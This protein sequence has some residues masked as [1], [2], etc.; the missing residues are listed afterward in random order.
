MNKQINREDQEITIDLL[1]V[2]KTLWR[3]KWVIILTTLF[4][5]LIVGAFTKFFITPKYTSTTSMYVFVQAKDSN[6]NNV[7]VSQGLAKDSV[8]LGTSETVLGTAIK[9]V[10]ES[11]I[12]AIT[13]EREENTNGKSYD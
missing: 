7:S 3:H 1:E 2:A 6:V 13:N 4:A 11:A 12:N 5:F 8:E 10:G 9:N